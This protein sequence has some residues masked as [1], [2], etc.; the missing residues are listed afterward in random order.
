MSLN[1]SLELVSDWRSAR[2]AWT[3]FLPLAALLAWAALTAGDAGIAAAVAALAIA[4]SLIAQFRL[5]DDLVDRGRDRAAHPERI[6][7]RAVSAT[8]FAQTVGLLFAA[9]A[10]ALAGV[11]GAP[12]LAGFLLLNATAAVWYAWHHERKLVHVLV[13]H[14][15]YP[16]FVLLLSP[17]GAVAPLAGAAIVYAALVGYELLD[18]PRLRAR[19]VT[20]LP[21]LP[22]ALAAIGLM[23]VTLEG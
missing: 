11:H 17:A 8:P 7:A 16:A 12:T 1:S 13:L 9:N 15:K 23:V 21:Y 5:W 14:L 3:R 19:M 22:L 18:E 2:F 10:I 6:V 20:W 4:V